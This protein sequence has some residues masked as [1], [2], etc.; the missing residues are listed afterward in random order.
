M[1]EEFEQTEPDSFDEEK[2]IMLSE[3]AL[4]D[5]LEFDEDIENLPI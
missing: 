1:T 4:E 3:E 2:E 5:N